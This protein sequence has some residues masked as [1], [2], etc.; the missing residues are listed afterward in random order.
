MQKFKWLT[1]M[2]TCLLAGGF[3]LAADQWLHVK[4]DA[5]GEDGESVRVNIPLS[6]VETVLPMIEAEHLQH[7]MLGLDDEGLEGLDLRKLL[8]ALRDTP[9]TNFVTVNSKDESVRVAKEGDFF[10]VR[11]EEKSGGENVLVKVPMAAVEALLSGTDGN[12]LNIMA[13]IEALGE[14]KGGDLVTVQDG[15]QFVRI[16]IDTSNEIRD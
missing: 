2:L 4:V 8:Q 5:T 6:L 3:I 9:D 11:V 13:A 12:Q 10:I 7:G 1:I 16:W 15:D 14:Y